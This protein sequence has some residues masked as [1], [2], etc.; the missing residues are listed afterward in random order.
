[1]TECG[2]G[3]TLR[4]QSCVQVCEYMELK[5]AYKFI[6]PSVGMDARY[7]SAACIINDVLTTTTTS[8]TGRDHDELR[9]GSV[10]GDGHLQV[11]VVPCRIHISTEN[12]H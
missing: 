1:M 9:V 11:C 8:R 10:G 7:G 3:S 6:T 4:V 12:A 2:T 5:Q